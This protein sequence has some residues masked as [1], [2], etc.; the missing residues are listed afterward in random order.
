HWKEHLQII[1]KMKEGINLRGYA[2]K[3]PLIEYK[4]EAFNAFENLNTVI[5]ADVIEKI[6]KVQLVAQEPGAEDILESL[7]PEEQDLSELDYQS[8]SDENLGADMGT[9]SS[10][11]SSSSGSSERQKMTFN[12]QSD[13]DSKQNRSERRKQKKR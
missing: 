1:D 12:R 9:S 13:Q 3:D 8:P 7:R 4:K 6:M 11:S 2:S 10:S 5:R